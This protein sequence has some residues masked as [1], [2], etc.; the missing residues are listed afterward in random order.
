MG[1]FCWFQG[2]GSLWVLVVV[3]KLGILVSMESSEGDLH[4][5]REHWRGTNTNQ[6]FLGAA[7]ANSASFHHKSSFLSSPPPKSI[8]WHTGNASRTHPCPQNS[9][10]TSGKQLDHFM[11]VF[12]KLSLAQVSGRCFIAD[13]F[14]LHSKNVHNVFNPCSA[15]THQILSLSPRADFGFFLEVMASRE[16][17]IHQQ[18]GKASL[19]H[20]P[21]L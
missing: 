13:L 2:L 1:G 21:T 19:G 15:H 11:R 7:A 18:G 14:S 16:F 10:H 17:S 20:P 9:S 4:S 6:A 5:S 8:A 12:F 3:P